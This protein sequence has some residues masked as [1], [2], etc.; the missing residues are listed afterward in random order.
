[1]HDASAV[2]EEVYVCWVP[3]RGGVL[4][5]GDAGSEV[6]VSPSIPRIPPGDVC[7]VLVGSHLTSKKRHFFLLYSIF[8][9]A[10]SGRTGGFEWWTC[11]GFLRRQANEQTRMTSSSGEGSK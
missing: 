1:M 10:T 4:R 7:S 3:M 9:G 2:E 5:N 11:G 6:G 8:V